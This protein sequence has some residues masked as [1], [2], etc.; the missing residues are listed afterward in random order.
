MENGMAFKTNTRYYLKLLT[1]ETM[2]LPG[3]TKNK[4]SKDKNGE[5][6]PHLKLLKL[7]YY[8]VILL[9]MVKNMFKQPCI[10]CF[11]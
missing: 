1:P 3:R 6:E 2:K 7:Y 10:L 9:T 11:K 4:I 8:I 5:N